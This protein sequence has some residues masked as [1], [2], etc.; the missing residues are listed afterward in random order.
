MQVKKFRFNTFL[1]MLLT[2]DPD[3][4]TTP[5]LVEGIITMHV[6]PP[7]NMCGSIEEVLLAWFAGGC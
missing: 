4:G 7:P 5:I 2:P 1:L 6:A 3:A